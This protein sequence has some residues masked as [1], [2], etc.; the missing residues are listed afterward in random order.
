MK[1]NVGDYIEKR[2]SFSYDDV[3]VFGDL[4]GD[5]NPLHFD[6]E[7]AS[8]TVF[9]KPIVHGILIASHI[10]SLIANELPG[11]GSIYLHQ[12]LNFKAPLF[13]SEEFITRIEVVEIK[14][15]KNIYILET[16]C[17]N[18]NSQVIVVGRAIIKA[19]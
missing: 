10:S 13:H 19:T 2:R 5:H 18:N 16:T 4:S 7:Y 9:K 11:S 14:V 1:Y 12:E 17:T 8:R 6:T 3:K 15:E